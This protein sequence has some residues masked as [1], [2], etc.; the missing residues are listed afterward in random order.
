MIDIM[1]RVILVVPLCGTRLLHDFWLWSEPNHAC[2]WSSDI[3]KFQNNQFRFS[4]QTRSFSPHSLPVVR[5]HLSTKQSTLDSNL[6]C[7]NLILYQVLLQSPRPY[8]SVHQTI[9]IWASWLVAIPQLWTIETHETNF[10]NCEVLQT[11]W[12]TAMTHRIFFRWGHIAPWRVTWA[13]IAP[14]TWGHIQMGKEPRKR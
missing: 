5:R 2:H 1:A 8:V 9:D 14:G 11:P 13:S 3:A 12:F 7:G 4:C 10:K 6:R